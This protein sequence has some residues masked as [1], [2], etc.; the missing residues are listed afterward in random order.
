VLTQEGQHRLCDGALWR[1]V[2]QQVAIDH[3]VDVS[4]LK[5]LEDLN[6]RHKKQNPV[7][8]SRNETQYFHVSR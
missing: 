1:I 4:C 6:R 8:L 2:A 7:N 3:E 5:R